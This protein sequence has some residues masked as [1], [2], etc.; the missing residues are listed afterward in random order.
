MLALRM[1]AADKILDN[2]I[3]EMIIVD[4]ELD[5]TLLIEISTLSYSD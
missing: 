2:P 3:P 5:A 1:A 4:L